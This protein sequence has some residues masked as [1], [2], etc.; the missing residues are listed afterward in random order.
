MTIRTMSLC[1]TKSFIK[2]MH[3]A[4]PVRETRT[5]Y[6]QLHSMAHSQG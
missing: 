1:L 2:L 5:V 4:A 6:K 3:M